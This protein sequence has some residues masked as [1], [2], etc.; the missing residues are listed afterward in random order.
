MDWTDGLF[1]NGTYY[2]G[3]VE[4]ANDRLSSHS[5]ATVTCYGTRR[6]SK[7]SGNTALKDK[8]NTNTNEVNNKI[9]IEQIIV[10]LNSH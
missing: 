6:S 1:Q 8:E 10:T 9:I 4:N 2:E 7:A 5:K 3:W